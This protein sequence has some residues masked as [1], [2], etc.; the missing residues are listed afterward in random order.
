MPASAD[1]LSSARTADISQ[2]GQRALDIARE[3]QKN[4]CAEVSGY[5][6]PSLP[7]LTSLH[8]TLFILWPA[9]CNR[10]R[11][12]EQK[13]LKRERVEALAVT[14]SSA[15]QEK[16]IDLPLLSLLFTFL[17]LLTSLLLPFPHRKL[18]SFLSDLNSPPLNH[19]SL[20]WI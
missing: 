3:R 11:E 1:I 14:L 8:S 7:A 6:H 19:N 20:L 4:E 10:Q 17:T 15:V 5:E 2:E 13:Q 18:R 12:R 9:S 16:V